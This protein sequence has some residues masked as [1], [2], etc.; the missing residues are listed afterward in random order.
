MVARTWD[1]EQFTTVNVFVEVRASH[2]NRPYLVN[3]PRSFET[4]DGELL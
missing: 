3:I 1:W 4:D 2:C